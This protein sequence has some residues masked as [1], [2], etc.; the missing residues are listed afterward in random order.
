M[1]L[2]IPARVLSVGVDHPDLASV[3]MVGATRNINVGLLDEG[4]SVRVGDWI[5]VH[6]GFALQKM[7]EQEAI[8]AID[9][10]S[11]ERTALSDWE[12]T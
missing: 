11:A 9:A 10:L 5:L 1:C 3:D 8:D 4:E 6:M 7:T 2:G 12:P